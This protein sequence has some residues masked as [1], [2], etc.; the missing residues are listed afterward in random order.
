MEEIKICKKCKKRVENDWKYCNFCGADLDKEYIYPKLPQK[1]EYSA[2]LICYSIIVLMILVSLTLNAID[3]GGVPS[4]ILSICI[5]VVVPNLIYYVSYKD[6]LD[7]YKYNCN[8]LINDYQEYENR[9]KA[10]EE[11]KRLIQ[12]QMQEML[13]SKEIDYTILVSEDTKKSVSSTVVRGAIGGALL[14]PVGLAAGALSG[15]NKA[16][17]TFTIVYKNGNREVI[18]VDNDSSDFNKYAKY[19]R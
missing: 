18:T 19:L 7:N 10:R 14:G 5:F 11:S 15:K 17:T 13:I 4:G 8:L 12:E 1:P 2:I 6:E 9:T 16:Q 3:V